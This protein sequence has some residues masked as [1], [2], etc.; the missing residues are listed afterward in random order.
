[1][2]IIE[3]MKANIILTIAAS[4][5]L[6]FA[7]QVGQAQTQSKDTQFFETKIRPLLIQHCHQCHSNDKKA[8]GGLRLDTKSG[9][10]LGGESGPAIVAGAVDKSIL[11]Q[12]VQSDD[13][14]SIMPPKNSGMPLNAAQIADLVSW[15]QNGAFDPR[16]DSSPHSTTKDWES[17]FRERMNWW[18]LRPVS[19][20]T[21]PDSNDPNLE[22]PTKS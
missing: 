5:L 21:P 3:H 9:W 13:S 15:V 4:V 11:I 12:R 20:V 10:Q 22:F 14:D 1:M 18:S 16:E 17:L 2:G 6:W 7:V 8:E 19:S